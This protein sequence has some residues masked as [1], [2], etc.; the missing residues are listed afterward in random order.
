MISVTRPDRSLEMAL[1]TETDASLDLGVN[2]VMPQAQAPLGFQLAGW[3]GRR[4]LLPL[5][6][7]PSLRRVRGGRASAARRR[8]AKRLASRSNQ[9]HTAARENG[10]RGAPPK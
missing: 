4:S 2:V 9:L 10:R 6:R 8:V 7:G 3:K 5:G 1:S